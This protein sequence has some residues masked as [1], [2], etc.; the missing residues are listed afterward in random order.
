MVVNSPCS[1]IISILRKGN[2][3]F[4]VSIEKEILRCWSALENTL[5]GYSVWK[6]EKYRRHNI[7]KKTG[8]NSRRQLLINF[9]HV[10][11]EKC[12]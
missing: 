10:M 1:Q 5:S 12:L 9:L 7:D 11:T 3:F 8:S 2:Y 4:S 6:E